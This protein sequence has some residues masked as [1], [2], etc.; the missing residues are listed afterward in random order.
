MDQ[1]F[2]GS[3]LLHFHLDNGS[4]AFVE[5]VNVLVVFVS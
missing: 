2:A 1:S 5:S 4:E 3:S